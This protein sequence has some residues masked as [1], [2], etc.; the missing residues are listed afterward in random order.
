MGVDLLNY[1]LECLDMYYK[2][3]VSIMKNKGQLR[4][5]MEGHLARGLFRGKD[6][7]LS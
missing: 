4:L 7:N 1:V 2:K 3:W 6:R 5:P